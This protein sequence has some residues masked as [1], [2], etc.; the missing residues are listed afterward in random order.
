MEKAIRTREE[1]EAQILAKNPHSDNDT[2]Q[3]LTTLSLTGEEHL[4]DL[5]KRYP[6]TPEE[7]LQKYAKDDE[8]IAHSVLDTD[9]E[10]DLWESMLLDGQEEE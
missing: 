5:R 6:G 4:A 8:M 7:A 3:A 10:L 2:I 1:V 9:I